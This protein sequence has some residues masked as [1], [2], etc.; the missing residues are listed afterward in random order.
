MEFISGESREQI[1]LTPDRVDGYVGENN[2]VRVIDA[3][4]NSLHLIEL[5]FS[6]AWLDTA[7]ARLTLKT[8]LSFTFMGVR[9]PQRLEA[10]PGS[11]LAFGEAVS[12]SQDDSA[13]SA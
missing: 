10:E 2:S 12:G 11:N 1:I 6:G 5:G 7:G 8:C 3:Y 4:I 9:S 13:V